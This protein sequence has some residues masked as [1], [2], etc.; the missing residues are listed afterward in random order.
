MLNQ[1]ADYKLLISTFSKLEPKE[2]N[3][4]VAFLAKTDLYFLC[5]YVFGWKFYDCDFAFNLCKRVTENPNKLWLV[6]RGHLKSLTITTAQNIQDILNNPELCIAIMSYNMKTAKAFL[7]QIKSILEQNQIL[8]AA[9]PHILYNNPVD[10]AP[11]WSEQDGIT[12]KRKSI[13]KEPTFYA[14]GLVDSQATGFHFDV[15]SFDDAVTQ[16]SVT[17]DEMIR[18][19]TEA[20]QLSDNLGMMGE[21]S[22]VKRY[23]GTRY[24]F[25]DTYGEMMKRG[26]PF[27]IIPATDNGEMDGNPVFLTMKQL[28]E[29][30]NEQGSYIFS[31]QN[32]L[33]PIAK[34]DQ[35]F[36]RDMVLY[37]DALPKCNMYIAIDPAN[38]QRKK[39]DYTA[40]L[41]FGFSADRKVYLVD[42][43]H[44][45]INLRQ[46]YD[47]IRSMHDR[48]DFK[49]IGY[50]R[51][52]MQTDVDYFRMEGE[53][54]NKFLPLYEMGGSMSKEDRVR[55]LVALFERGDLLFPKKLEYWSNFECRNV[56]IVQRLIFEM[57]S[58]PFGEHDDLLDCLSRCFDL[59]LNNPADRPE[60]VVNPADR[61]IVQNIIDRNKQK[62]TRS[63]W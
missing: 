35:V 27:E 36:T 31:C 12:I 60:P 37:Y 19:T 29:K 21:R 24:H 45:K 23:A 6:A 54:E 55:R 18:K 46:R 61:W 56:D 57:E 2:L 10:E 13:R 40:G 25:F 34:E 11:K 52:G 28:E 32:L 43:I 58:F 8:K 38:S 59:F 7:R 30:K 16:D 41:V 9:F 50:E 14:F 5:W 49:R 26:V 22:T 39:S 17:S 20:W 51:Y 47:K 1:R 44:D 33:K 4:T 63:E 3:D 53:R 48:Y 42:A 15:H 62:Q